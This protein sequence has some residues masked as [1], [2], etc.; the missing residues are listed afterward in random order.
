MAYFDP[1][2]GTKGRFTSHLELMV[3]GTPAALMTLRAKLTLHNES[4]KQQI[5]RL[6][7]TKPRSMKHLEAIQA[8]LKELTPLQK[9]VCYADTDEGVSIPPGC[10]FM[11]EH[12]ENPEVIAN[13]QMDI[14]WIGDER[15][16]QTT[17]VEE[18]LKWKRSCVQVT[19]GGGKSRIIQTMCRTLTAINKR[20]LVV[21]PSIELLKQTFNPLLADGTFTVTKFGGGETPRLGCQV[22]VSTLQSATGIVDQFDAIITDELQHNSCATVQA[23][24]SS[25]VNAEYVYGMS[26]SPWRADGMTQ[27]I[28][29]FAG[30][31]VFKYTGGRAIK[32]GYLSPLVY[33]QR[34]IPMTDTTTKY[35]QPIKRYIKLHSDDK[36]ISYVEKFV[37]AAL[38][39]HR[40]VLVLFRS[41]QCCKKLG[42]R[43]GVNSADGAFRQPFYA[44]KKGESDLCIANISLLG[45][46]IDVPSISA[47]I[48]C[49]GST[50]EISVVQAFGRG[51]RKTE[52]KKDC[53]IVDVFPDLPDWKYKAKQRERYYKA[54]FEDSLDTEENR[55]SFTELEELEPTQGE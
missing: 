20:V 1:I 8:Q 49:A 27:L 34:A 13:P 18:L 50:S 51:T 36:Y 31:I 25:A 7:K 15:Y 46:G 55:I 38:D 2:H 3:T 52:G 23:M 30:P 11:V 33:T 45:E 10:Y 21:V 12:L 26:A 44:F 28:W 43:L 17:A 48:Y 40:R 5:T 16:Y 24:F 54:H 47:I 14:K 4:V 41:T 6:K 29:N 35:M 19:T 42:K 22:V 39:K 9:V 32:E 37:R 53:V